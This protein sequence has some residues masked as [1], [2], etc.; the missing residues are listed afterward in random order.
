M[1]LLMLMSFATC[2]SG[3]FLLFL[4]CSIQ[5]CD[6][7]KWSNKRD[8]NSFKNEYGREDSEYTCYYNPKTPDEAFQERSSV[9]SDEMKILHCVLWPMLLIA[10]SVG[11]L[12][13]LL[14]R[15]KGFFCFKK[16]SGSAVPYQN[17][18]PTAWYMVCLKNNTEHKKKMC[19][20]LLS[21]VDTYK[22]NAQKVLLRISKWNSI[23]HQVEVSIITREVFFLV[24]VH[25]LSPVV[26]MGDTVI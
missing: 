14:C 12:G 7:V 10:I 15:S 26:T 4:Q 24:F 23:V 8:V 16:T 6:S 11:L 13:T 3:I 19:R 5:P 1:F 2:N 17:L 25:F 20:I 21:L 9:K 18:Q 22:G